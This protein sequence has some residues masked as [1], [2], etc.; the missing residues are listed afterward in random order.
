MLDEPAPTLASN[1]TTSYAD[2]HNYYVTF[3][4]EVKQQYVNRSNGTE[5]RYTSFI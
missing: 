4:D 3:Y 2:Q 5:V 1:E